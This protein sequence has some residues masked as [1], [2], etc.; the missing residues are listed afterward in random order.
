MEKIIEQ[1]PEVI[2]DVSMEESDGAEKQAKRFWREWQDLPAVKNNKVAALNSDLI[3]RPGPRLFDGLL[4][5]AKILH[6]EKFEE[7]N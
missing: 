5:L 4:E 7:K 6:S 2:I 1:S 3:T